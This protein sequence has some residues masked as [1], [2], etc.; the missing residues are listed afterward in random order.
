ME[1]QVTLLIDGHIHI[2]PLYKL[3]LAIKNGIANLQQCA[4]QSNVKD[5]NQRQVPVWLLV[6]RYDCNFFDQITSG[7]SLTMNGFTLQSAEDGSTIIVS[8]NDAPVLYIF[9]GRQL[10]TKENLEILSLVT[11]FNLKDRKY[12]IMKITVNRN[13]DF[14]SH[15]SRK[16]LARPAHAFR[17]NS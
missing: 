10:V 12:S 15:R 5:K 2:Y 13:S 4:K 17:K 16:T 14:R 3:T 8:E 7:S 11:P 9:A 6:E 1:K